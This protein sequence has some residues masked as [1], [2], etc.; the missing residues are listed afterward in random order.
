MLI[1]PSFQKGLIIFSIF[2]Q[3]TFKRTLLDELFRVIRFSK[4]SYALTSLFKTVKLK[5]GMSLQNGMWH[6]L[7]NDIIM[8]N[9][10]YAE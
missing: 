2:R 7:R 8:R 3:N 5:G 4:A 1:V 6:G 10:I 9:V